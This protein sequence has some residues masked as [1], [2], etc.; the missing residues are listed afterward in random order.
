M[1]KWLF[2][3][4]L[5]IIGCGPSTVALRPANTC[6][7]SPSGL[8]L[9]RDRCDDNEARAC[10]RL[11][12]FYETGQDVD[13]DIQKAVNHYEKACNANFA[14]ACRALGQIYWDGEEVERD[15]DRSIAYFRKACT[16]GVPEACPTKAMVAMSQG[17]RPAPGET[18]SAEISVD[19]P[20]APE[21]PAAPESPEV[22][23]PEVPSETPA[24]EGPEVP[25]PSFP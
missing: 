20:D 21:G 4:T 22:S 2:L 7:S 1:H 14:V 23:T 17:R 3:G 24:V 11:G 13:E 5:A 8:K 18:I 9:C 16:L 12:W 19:G 6:D 25:T 15:W 10:Y